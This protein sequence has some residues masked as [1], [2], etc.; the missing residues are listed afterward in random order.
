[1]RS[2]RITR[3]ERMENKLM[4]KMMTLSFKMRKKKMKTRKFL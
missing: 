1:M 2:I 3:I 4:M